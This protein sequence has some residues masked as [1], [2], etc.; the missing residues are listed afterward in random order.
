MLKKHKIII[1]IDGLSATGKSTLAKALAQKIGYRYIDTGAMYRAVAL[2]FQSHALARL[3]DLS[4]D[5]LRGIA[6]DLEGDR[7]FLNKKDVS[8][9]IRLEKISQR[10]PILSQ[11]PKVRDWLLQ[12]QRSIG[13][14]KGVVMDGR[15]IGTVVFP[16]AAL[17]IYLTADAWVRARR[18][19]DDLGD[20]TVSLEEMKRR[21]EA[22]DLQDMNRAIAPLKKAPDA[23]HMD[24]SHMTIDQQLHMIGA[25]IDEKTSF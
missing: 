14:G 24:N 2:H 21:L 20:E 10:V 4:A 22:R 7:I 19:R 17:K 18:R 8:K 11:N 13:S 12:Q 15:D 25:L 9:E 3:N 6:I 16:K 23:I 5:M 1:A